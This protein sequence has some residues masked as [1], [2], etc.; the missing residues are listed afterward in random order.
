MMLQTDGTG[1]GMDRVEVLEILADLGGPGR[2]WLL[3]LGRWRL[4]CRCLGWSADAF[5]L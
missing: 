1:Q 5:G 4:G 3:G 2:G